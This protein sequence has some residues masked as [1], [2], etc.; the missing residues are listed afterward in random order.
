M[1]YLLSTF[2]PSVDAI[3]WTDKALRQ[4]GDGVEIEVLACEVGGSGC[5]EM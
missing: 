5:V 2:T 4:W 3:G 1:Y